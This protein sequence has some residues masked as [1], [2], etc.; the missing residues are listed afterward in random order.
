VSR[1]LRFL[2]LGAT[3]QVG[4][5][6]QRSFID[7]GEVIALDRKGADLSRPETLRTLIAEIKPNVIL[8]AAAYTAVDRAESEPELAMIINGEAPRVLAE[9][10]AKHDAILVH[11]STDYVFNGAK[12]SPWLETDEPAPL[13]VYGETKLAGEQAIQESG[14]KH[15]IFRTSWVFGPH[16]QNFLRTMLRLGAERDQLRIVDD[17]IGTPTS[18]I[19]IANATRAVVDRILADNINSQPSWSGVYHM[20][21]GGMTSWCSFA[22]EIFTQGKHFLNGKVPEV[23]PISSEQYPTP[24]KRPLYSVLSN[25]KF[26]MKLGLHLPMWQE[27]LRQS[28]G[29]LPN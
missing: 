10:A 26:V 7:A 14:A 1:Q 9:A 6:L 21:C 18:S 4:V 19:A 11:Y 23:I 22:N 15:L 20:T 13:N 17:Q 5:E 12:T 27:A 28:L 3:G 8:N 2:I 29:M 16:G 25:D 24:A